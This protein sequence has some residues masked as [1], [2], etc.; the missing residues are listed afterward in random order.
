MAI[1]LVVIFQL[2][3]MAITYV[4]DMWAVKGLYGSAV[5]LGLTDVDALTV[6]MSS[7]STAILPSIA[8][9]A[10]VIGILANTIVKL[11]IS[12]A[13]G[14]ARYRLVAGGALLAMAAVITLTLAAR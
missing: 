9:R 3:I 2:G 5:L 1:R 14:S 6:S 8:A 11:T 7:P 10:I 4:R 12:V 13:L